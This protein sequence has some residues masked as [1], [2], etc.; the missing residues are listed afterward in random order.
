MQAELACL[1]VLTTLGAP[2]VHLLN[3]TVD[4]VE[5]GNEDINY[6][7]CNVAPSSI[8]EEMEKHH[9]SDKL[10]KI[11]KHFVF[12]DAYTETFGFEDDVLK[13]R[14]REMEKKKRIHIVNSNSA[15]GIHS[16][17][18]KAFKILKKNA[19]SGQS[20]RRSCTMIYDTLSVLSIPETD[21]EVA[22]FIIHLAAAE[23]A[24]Q[25][26]TIFLEPDIQGRQSDAIAALRSC[27]GTPIIVDS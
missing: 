13:E 24:Y 21:A 12:V 5:S 17:T 23:R 10:N 1:L 15:A 22:E 9:D 2:D 8:W 20:E 4:L 7:C 27:C 26:R 19:V 6:V 3:L 18:A 11:K 14:L 25:M 16:G